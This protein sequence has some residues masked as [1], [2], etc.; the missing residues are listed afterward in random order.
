M[1]QPKHCR[2]RRAWLQAAPNDKVTCNPSAASHRLNDAL[3]NAMISGI[4]SFCAS[5]NHE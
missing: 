5:E 2:A 3:A 4:T 1:K